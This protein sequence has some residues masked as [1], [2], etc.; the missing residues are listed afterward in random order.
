LQ[1][2]FLYPSILV[3]LW[4]QETSLQRIEQ[5]LFLSQGKRWLTLLLDE[6]SALNKKHRDKISD[7]MNVQSL[8]DL[9]S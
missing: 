6:L 7:N 9:V 2:A 8:P 3:C 1:I 4:L 5:L